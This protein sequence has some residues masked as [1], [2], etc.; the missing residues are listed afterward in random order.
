MV[1]ETPS[2]SITK[3]FFVVCFQLLSTDSRLPKL[4]Y[5]YTSVITRG[6][7]LPLNN[8]WTTLPHICN[9]Y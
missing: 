7:S 4:D 2:K 8:L 5:A 6:L 9:V 3:E 1:P